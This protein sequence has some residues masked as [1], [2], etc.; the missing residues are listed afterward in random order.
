MFKKKYGMAY[1]KTF[2]NFLVKEECAIRYV[3]NVYKIKS[4]K[5]KITGYLKNIVPEDYVKVFN[6]ENTDEG[7]SF[8][9]IV[10]AK[11]RYL[12]KELKNEN[13][14]DH[15]KQQN[16]SKASGIIKKKDKGSLHNGRPQIFKRK[17]NG[18]VA[19]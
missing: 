11:W 12:I 19:S 18:E 6:W 1:G 14:K 10:N 16:H 4:Q 8:W 13:P 9:N 5:V 15:S 3:R 2:L 7:Y 17:K